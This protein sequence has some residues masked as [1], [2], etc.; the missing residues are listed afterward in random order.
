MPRARERETIIA[1]HYESLLQ[2]EIMSA[3]SH[4][5]VTGNPVNSINNTLLEP[6]RVANVQVDNLDHLNSL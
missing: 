1:T 5:T 3:I 6:K 4:N 2:Q